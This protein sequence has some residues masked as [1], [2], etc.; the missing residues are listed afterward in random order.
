MHGDLTDDMLPYEPETIVKEQSL[1][2]RY[3]GVPG[4][5]NPG[6]APAISPSVPQDF[7]INSLVPLD[8]SSCDA[9]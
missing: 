9:S 7:D 5:A 2:M 4:L 6:Q 3:A 1:I 8:V